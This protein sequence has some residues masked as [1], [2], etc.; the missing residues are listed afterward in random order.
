MCAICITLATQ[1][2][3]GFDY[4]GS[5]QR[6]AGSTSAH[7]EPVPRSSRVLEPFASKSASGERWFIVLGL[8]APF[9][10]VF[11]VHSFSGGDFGGFDRWSECLWRGDGSL[12]GGGSDANYPVVGIFA[13]PG[14]VGTL[15]HLVHAHDPLVVPFRYYLAA[16]S[17]LV[18]LLMGALGRLMDSRRPWLLAFI[19][20]AVPSSW[21][22]GPV[23]CQIVGVTQLFLFASLLAYG[24]AWRA[25][26]RG[27]LTPAIMWLALGQM[28]CWLS[29]LT[30]Q[31]SIFSV[32]WLF[33]CSLIA[34]LQLAARWRLRGAAA[35]ALSFAATVGIAALIDRVLHVPDGFHGSSLAYIWLGG[36]SD[37]GSRISNNGFNVWMLLGRDMA[38][39]S[40][41]P[42]ARLH[43]NDLCFEL[44]PQACG[45][46]LFLLSSVVF[47]VLFLRNLGGWKRLRGMLRGFREVEL[48]ALLIDLC[49]AIGLQNLAANVWLTGTHERYMYHG[50][51]FLLLACVRLWQ[52]PRS[53][54][55]RTPAILIA[56][57]SCYAGFVMAQISSLPSLLFP[58]RRHELMVAMHVFLFVMLL[59]IFRTLG[60]RLGFAPTVTRDACG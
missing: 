10:A 28:S 58:L 43:W 9:L 33:L 6:S 26:G 15:R 12:Y 31:L 37:H 30:K 14:V 50:Y 48:P 3:A 27:R 18:F 34:A 20:I 55:V 41:T 42:F 13:G 46:V 44:A 1:R 17:G 36:G 29:I 22:G 56:C 16:V 38:S 24:Y 35:A 45:K 4:S 8:L 52:R 49:L 23:W 2:R 5:M 40:L 59:D 11:A 47:F 54:G 57:A 32:P 39:S 51:F 19:V 21:A 7:G 60:R 25:T 53:L